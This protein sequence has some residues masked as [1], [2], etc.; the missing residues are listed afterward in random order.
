MFRLHVVSFISKFGRISDAHEVG[1]LS[2][3]L[4]WCRVRHIR[5]SDA[6]LPEDLT[7]DRSHVTFVCVSLYASFHSF[8][9][10]RE[11]DRLP[12]DITVS[13]AG[14]SRVI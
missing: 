4:R 3:C 8:T 1:V 6:I 11:V 12:P 10:C 13:R 7:P 9:L 14:T 2:A 5:V